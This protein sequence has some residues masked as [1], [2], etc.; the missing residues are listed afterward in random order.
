M[1]PRKEP[2]H[3]Y[4]RELG[5]TEDELRRRKEWLEF[6]PEDEARITSLHDMAERYQNDIIEDL[7][8]HFLAFPEVRAFFTEESILQHVKAM[9]RDYFLRLTGGNYDAAYIENRLNIGAVHE[10]VGVDVKW[11]LGAYNHYV[12]FIGRKIYE[13]YPDNP[14][15]ALEAFASLT[16]IIYL[17]IGLAIDM[18]IYQRERTIRAQ[19]EAIRELSTPVLQLREGLLLLPIVGAIDSHRARQITTSLL[20]AIRDNRARV[21]VLDVTGVPAMDSAVANHLVQTVDAARLMGAQAIMT[22]L[23]PEIAQTLATLGVTLGQVHTLGD[24]QGGIEAAEHILRGRPK[25]RA[26]SSWHLPGG[27]ENG[28]E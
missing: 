14:Q 15:R 22:G 5:I 24:L 2:D 9:Q 19:Q 28:G 26:Q 27:E 3:A 20:R 21:V 11:Y 10:R 13:M 25:E 1:A 18:Y 12:R 17:D 16:K 4:M 6:T 7:Y 23:S 8:E